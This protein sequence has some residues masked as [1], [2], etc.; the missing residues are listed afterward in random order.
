MFTTAYSMTRTACKFVDPSSIHGGD[1][2]KPWIHLVAGNKCV[3]IE[4]GSNGSIRALCVVKK[5]TGQGATKIFHPRKV[6]WSARAG[7]F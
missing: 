7:I 1:D 4:E 2:H 6:A 5:P 3:L